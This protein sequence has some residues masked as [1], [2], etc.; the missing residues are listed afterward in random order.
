VKLRE[1]TWAEFVPFLAFDQKILSVIYPTNA[2][3]S[4][5]VGSVA[6]SR[7]VD[8]SRMRMRRCMPVSHRHE[9][10]PNGSAPAKVDQSAEKVLNAF[11]PAFEGRIIGNQK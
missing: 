9:L 2:I 6:P 4:L 11:E 3:E 8:T 10:G 5:N 1:N 7:P